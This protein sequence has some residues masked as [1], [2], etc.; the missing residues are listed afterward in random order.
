MNSGQCKKKLSSTYLTQ[1]D[2]GTKS[3]LLNCRDCGV[4]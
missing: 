4:S 1:A 2:T 3:I